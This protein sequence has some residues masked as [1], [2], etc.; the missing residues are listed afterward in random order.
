MTSRTTSRPTYSP[1]G[2]WI[3]YSSVHGTKAKIYRLHADAPESREQ[4][5]YGDWNDEDPAISPD[6]KKLF[7]TSDRDGGIY[8]IYSINLETRRDVP[9]YQRCRRL[10]LAD[11]LLARDGSER[12]VFSAYYKRRFTLYVNDS[13]KPFQKLAELNPR[14]L[15]PAH[16]DR[17]LPAVD[18]GRAGPREDQQEA[19]P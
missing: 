6:G 17:A 16:D 9:P 14:R 15:R 12:L 13:K 5:T 18:R 8:N 3:Y 19:Q 10:L 7:F 11:V 2:Q 1:D 4:V